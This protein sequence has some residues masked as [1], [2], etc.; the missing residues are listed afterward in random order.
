MEK[1]AKARLQE[2]VDKYKV[3]GAKLI[4][5]DSTSHSNAVNEYTPF[6]FTCQYIKNTG[7]Q[8]FEGMHA[9]LNTW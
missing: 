5:F 2:K 8:T 1:P 9:F 3:F 7:G 4:T 6:E